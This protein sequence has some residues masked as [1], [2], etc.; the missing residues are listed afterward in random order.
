MHVAVVKVA[1]NHPESR[2]VVGQHLLRQHRFNESAQ[3]RAGRRDETREH[4]AANGQI[5]SRRQNRRRTLDDRPKLAVGRNQIRK[6]SIRQLVGPDAPS[7]APAENHNDT[8]AERERSVG[9]LYDK[10]I[11]SKRL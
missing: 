1:M 3:A 2:R 6:L 11:P 4:L 5:V 9:K 8:I 7:G 10:I